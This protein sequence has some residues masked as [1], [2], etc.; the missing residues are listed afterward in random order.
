MAVLRK[1]FIGFTRLPW[2]FQPLE[3][4]LECGA[5]VY[6]PLGA[7]AFRHVQAPREFNAA[8]LVPLG[9]DLVGAR[10]LTGLVH[11]L[12]FR[13]APVEREASHT[14]RLGEM[15]RL[16]DSRVQADLVGEDHGSPP[17]TSCSR[18]SWSFFL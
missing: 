17:F 10:L 7:T 2:L 13:Q 18:T 12:P 9:L 8:N 1:D 4:V 5:K 6:D 14:S 11:P 3:E 15:D 16:F